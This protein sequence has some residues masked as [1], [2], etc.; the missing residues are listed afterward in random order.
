MKKQLTILILLFFLCPFAWSQGRTVQTTTPCDEEMLKKIPGRWMPIGRFL[1]AKNSIQQEQEIVRRLDVIQKMAFN[2]Y[3][4]PMAF[5]AVQGYGIAY[6]DFASQLKIET[7]PYGT[8]DSY[9]NGTSTIFYNYFVK[10]CDYFCGN[11]NK[12]EYF[13]GAGCETGTNIAV[14]INNLDP[15]FFPL[16]L[17]KFYK[18]I[19]RIDGRPINMLGVIREKK[20]KNYEV[21]SPENG[22]SENMIL[23]HRD[24]MLPYIPVTRKQY[25]DRSMQCL[26][27]QYDEIIKGYEQPEGLQLLMNKNE[28]DEGIKKNQKIRDDIIK[29]YKDELEATTRAGLHDIPA[30]ITG[31]I[32]IYT[33]QPIFTTQAK[34]GNMLVT[35][36]PA[37]FKKDLPK[38]I[39][40]LII[41][42]MWNGEDGPDPALN[43][44]HL[45]YQNFPIEKLQAM[46]DK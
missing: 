42:S 9:I 46:I 13:K 6:K 3:P 35:E 33:T 11:S 39:P 29:Y 15:L 1:S 12:N 30:V 23:I 43:P 5:D 36:N 37:Y 19:M 7:T 20:W 24:G 34:G 8:S 32:N 45:Y 44:Y 40:Q 18:E 31:F 10:F 41:Y 22:S 17:D 16:Y 28:R 38:Y 14:T 21:Y 4:E 26:N 27:R 2:V 25:L